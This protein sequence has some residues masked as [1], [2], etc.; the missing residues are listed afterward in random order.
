MSEFTINEKVI[1]VDKFLAD[2]WKPLITTL[3]PIDWSNAKQRLVES[4]LTLL[5]KNAE[6]P[7]NGYFTPN[8]NFWELNP[9]NWNKIKFSKDMGFGSEPYFNSFVVDIDLCSS[10]EDDNMYNLEL[11]KKMWPE[12]QKKLD[13]L[14]AKPTW[15]IETGKWYHL[16]WVIKEEDRQACWRKHWVRLLHLAQTISEHLWWDKNCVATKNVHAIMRVPFCKYWNKTT[17]EII[18]E[19][20]ILQH[21]PE[22]KLSFAMVDNT[23]VWVKYHKGITTENNKAIKAFWN[24]PSNAINKIPF[25]D[26]MQSL[27]PRVNKGRAERLELRWLHICIRYEDTGELYVPDWYR[28][29]PIRNSIT[30]FSISNH[31]IDDR[32]RWD[33]STFVKQRFNQDLKKASNF[34]HE[35]FGIS[36]QVMLTGGWE[37]I[38]RTIEAWW[39]DIVFTEKWVSKIEWTSEK[40]IFRQYVEIIGKW[41]VTK[42]S[43][44]LETEEKNLVYLFKIWWKQLM[45]NHCSQKT[46]FNKLYWNKCF[47]YWL[48]NDIGLF[49]EALSVADWIPEIEIV[50]HNWIY[51]NLVALGWKKYKEFWE[52]KTNRYYSIDA[53]FPTVDKN[54]KTVK[55]FIKSLCKIYDESVVIPCVLQWLALAGMNLWEWNIIYPGLLLTGKTG[56]GKSTL[57]LIIKHMVWQHMSARNYSLPATSAQPMSQ[58]STDCAILHFEELTDKVSS[59]SEQLLRNIINR[60]KW[61]R[62][63]WQWN[64]FYDYKSPLLITGER[65]FRDE[66]LNNRF[67]TIYMVKKHWVEKDLKKSKQLVSDILD[68][69]ASTDVYKTLVFNQNKINK[70]YKKYVAEISSKIDARHAD[71]WGYIY[72][73]N[74]I[75]ELWYTKEKMLGFMKTH[76]A[77]SGFGKDRSKFKSPEWDLKFILLKGMAKFDLNYFY[78]DIADAYNFVFIK[79]DYRESNRNKLWYIIEEI[80]WREWVDRIYAD[81]DA[82][83]VQLDMKNPTTTDKALYNLMEDTLSNLNIKRKKYAV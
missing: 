46:Q 14:M 69:T 56:T 70:I 63:V 34:L 16:H 21:N 28:Y 8:W 61:A 44:F 51:G 68:T 77:I 75:F 78:D 4:S 24:V 26:I 52:S 45:V 59:R 66:S 19:V 50:T 60:W 42:A 76:L 36:T 10:T 79:D 47:F 41:Y 22:A 71:V 2:F 3:N 72:A 57:A 23:M 13:M 30:V 25:R 33:M 74:D 43:N 67:L 83:V 81:S 17:Q 7:L 53:D 20:N 65:S 12:I 31:D 54:Q 48:D 37:I 18:G 58:Y 29:W 5:S 6:L 39:V 62:G 49:F 9:T 1:L 15:V 82:I 40:M 11:K 73:M 80:N 55:Q 38:E 32:P 64:L 35:K 27:P